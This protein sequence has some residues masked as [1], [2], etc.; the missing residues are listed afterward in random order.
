[1][2]KEQILVVDDDPLATDA[3]ACFFEME[4]YGVFKAGDGCEAL[5]IL[6]AQPAVRL[7]LTDVIMPNMDGRELLTRMRQD[8]RFKNIP[9]IVVCASERYVEELRDQAVAVMLKPVDVTNLLWL[10]ENHAGEH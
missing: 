5:E 10:V 2:N 7:V 4:G 8:A 6:N 9:V 1:M 3:M